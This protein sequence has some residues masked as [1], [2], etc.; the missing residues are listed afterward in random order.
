M[1]CKKLNRRNLY[2]PTFP[3]SIDLNKIIISFLFEINAS[4]IN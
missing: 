1:N 4:I 2:Y 3:N